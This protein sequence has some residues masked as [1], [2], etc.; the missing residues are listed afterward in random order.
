[1]RANDKFGRPI[2]PHIFRI[3]QRYGDLLSEKGYS[4]SYHKPNLFYKRTESL[5]FFADMRGTKEIPIWEDP[6]PLFYCKEANDILENWLYNRLLKQEVLTLWN[7][8]VPVR[9]SFEG[10]P[11]RG[12]TCINGEQR[13]ID[14]NDGFCRYCGKDMQKDGTFCS[15]K[16][17][18]TYDIEHCIT[19]W[20]CDVSINSWLHEKYEE[21]KPEV[22]HHIS[23]DPE[24]TITI[25]PSCHAKIHHSSEYPHL[26][27]NG[28]KPKGRKYKLV[29]CWRCRGRTRVPVDSPVTNA[30]CQKCRREI[31]KIQSQPGYLERTFGAK[32]R[33]R[34]LLERY[35]LSKSRT[36]ESGGDK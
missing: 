3:L 18:K 29:P 4:E 8:G 9:F 5:I 24:R 21:V 10:T 11:F 36:K 19:C 34:Q 20:L 23:Y 35:K 33:T 26:K 28:T 6:V 22:E 1:M 12:S 13:I 16:C 14:V 15:P 30:L 2:Y 27:L 25:C 32:W 31:K 7:A 17:E